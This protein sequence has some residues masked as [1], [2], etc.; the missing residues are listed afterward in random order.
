LEGALWQQGISKQWAKKRKTPT[1]TEVREM[2]VPEREVEKTVVDKVADFIED[3]VFIRTPAIYRLIAL[4]IAATH[5]YEQFE[6][7]GYLF[8]HSPEPSSGKSRLLEVLDVFVHNS[9]GILVSPSQ[10]VLFRTATDGTQLLDE[11]DSWTNHD[12]LRSVLNAGFRRGATVR[13]MRETAAGWEVD[14]L[15]AFAPRAMAG[16]GRNILTAATIDRTFAI[17][18]ARQKPKER[19]KQFR[20]RVVKPRADTLKAE[21]KEWVGA[22]KT[23]IVAC[24]ENLD[25]PYLESFRDRTIDISEPLAAILE[26]AYSGHPKLDQVRQEFVEALKIVRNEDGPLSRGNLILQELARLAG[27]ESPL[28]GTATELSEMCKALE[29]APSVTEVSTALQ[30]FGFKTKSIRKD[31]EPKYRYVLTSEKLD[32]LSSRYAPVMDED[33]QCAATASAEPSAV[34]GSGCSG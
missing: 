27:K 3:F 1:L 25:F 9:S 5:M 24:Y 34:P 23:E 22:H 4:W 14:S 17:E 26:V 19:R 10:A 20:L 31:G 18:M 12:E 33:A 16:I 13:R 15:L 2:P 21:V 28:T 8:A 32:E 29:P 6:Y 7:M 11:V 30:N